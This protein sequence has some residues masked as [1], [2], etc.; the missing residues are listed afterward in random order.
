MQGLFFWQTNKLKRNEEG[1]YLLK[2]GHHLGSHAHTHQMLTKQPYENQLSEI[3][4][5]KEILEKQFGS[6]IKYFRPPYGLYNEDT[7]AILDQLDMNIVLWQIA[8]WDWM[9]EADP[10]QIIENVID[11][12]TPGDIIL[13]HELEQT[14]EILPELITRIREKGLELRQRHQPLCFK[15]TVNI[16]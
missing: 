6:R 7:M 1:T 3:K 8:S 5:S 9:H 4:D 13:L 11:H 15:T 10:N 14:V 2:H 12:V 16:R